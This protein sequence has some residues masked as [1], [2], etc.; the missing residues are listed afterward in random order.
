M[1][2]LDLLAS[3]HLFVW[4]GQRSFNQESLYEGDEIA[5]FAYGTRTE[6]K[7]SY[8]STFYLRSHC[9]S[10]RS[11]DDEQYSRLCRQCGYCYSY[12]K[13][14]G[15]Q[16]GEWDRLDIKTLRQ[17]DINS[18][19]LGLDELGTHLRRRFDHAF[20]LNPTRFEEL[21]EDIYRQLGYSTRRTQQ[22]RDGGYDLVLLENSSGDQ[23][24]VECKR[25]DKDRK[26]G[27]AIIRELLGV[28]FLEGVHKSRIVT[29]AQFTKPAMETAKR[30]REKL[31]PIYMDLV[32]AKGLLKELEV[33]N[34]NLP[35]LEFPDIDEC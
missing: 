30:A 28:Q 8:C 2:K 7:C 33:Y 15:I 4:R 3:N 21:V 34:T 27:V 5:G 26:V 17:L 24:L 18:S 29:T 32:D 22:T 12:V 23:I 25:Y 11:G 14:H 9:S 20:A 6:Y 31:E 19:L 13:G 10:Y 1:S 35:P 16:D